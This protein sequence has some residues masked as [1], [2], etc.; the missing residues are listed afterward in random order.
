MT[1]LSASVALLVNTTRSG[2]GASKK[3]ASCC[4]V[5]STSRSASAAIAWLPLPGEAP[6]RENVSAI[7]CSAPGGFG[8]VV[9][10]LSR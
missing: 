8:N 7:D 4:R 5:S 2:S 10:A 6:T 3:L 1:R 9:A